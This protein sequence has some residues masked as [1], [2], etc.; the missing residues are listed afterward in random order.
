MKVKRLLTEDMEEVR[1]LHQDGRQERVEGGAG[2]PEPMVVLLYAQ[3]HFAPAACLGD[4]HTVTHTW[5][6]DTRAIAPV[7][8]LAGMINWEKIRAIM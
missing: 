5:R 4:N 3:A 8:L 2:E 7:A 1:V 6:K